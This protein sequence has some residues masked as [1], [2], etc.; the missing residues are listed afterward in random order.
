LPTS[1]GLV[2][3]DGGCGTS[4][5]FGAFGLDDQALGSIGPFTVGDNSNGG[6][7]DED[8]FFGVRDDAAFC[9]CASRIRAAASRSTIFSS[10]TTTTFLRTDS[11]R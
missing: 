9:A 5:T 4:V 10:M 8:R 2:W 1:A 3:T 11:T 7:T 6:D